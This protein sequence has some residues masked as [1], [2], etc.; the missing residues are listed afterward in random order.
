MP[1]KKLAKRTAKPAQSAANLPQL[2]RDF[3]TMPAKLASEMNKELS[4]LKKQESGLKK[5]VAQT[6][7]ELKAT[8]SR[9]KAAAKAKKS[10][11]S[12]KQLAAAKKALQ[13]ATKIH[14]ALITE[15][16]NVSKAIAALISRS[17]KLEAMRKALAQFEKDWAKKAKKAA[18]S[19]KIAKAAKVKAKR[20]KKKAPRLALVKQDAEQS[21][22]ESF[23]A[24]VE[25]VTLDQTAELA[26]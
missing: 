13:E 12:K 9:I 2:E 19:A 15:L 3:S 22:V 21:S 6:S 1:R 25:D 20:D 17:E 23:D 10:V 14:R 7:S 11:S 26:H 4:A 8:E 16:A 5:A 18:K 24:S